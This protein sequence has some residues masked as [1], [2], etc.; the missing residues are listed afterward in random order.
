MGSGSEQSQGPGCL[1]ALAAS[2]CL[3]ARAVLQTGDA[4][5][6]GPGDSNV[7]R[8]FLSIPARWSCPRVDFQR[9]W[10]RERCA[11]ASAALNLSVA[12]RHVPEQ[13]AWE[14]S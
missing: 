1:W 3:S 10:G 12:K 9:V 5:R 6:R 4:A 14:L 11:G 8:G 13:A 7:G 2:G